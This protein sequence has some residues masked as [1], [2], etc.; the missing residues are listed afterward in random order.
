M[1][2]GCCVPEEC[3][4]RGLLMETLYLLVPMS[5]VLVALSQALVVGLACR[6]VRR[7]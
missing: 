4:N 5:L 3:T 7:P 1:H 6:A 2:G